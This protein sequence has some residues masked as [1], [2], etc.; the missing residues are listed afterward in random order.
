MSRIAALACLLFLAANI[1]LADQP[2]PYAGQQLREIKALAPQDV[3]QY[4]EGKGMGLA[5]AAELNHFPGPMHVLQFEGKLQ[6]T[7][8]QKTQTEKIFAAMQLE[9]S[10]LGAPLVDKE[11]ELDRLFASGNI[12]A[13]RLGS[14]VMEIGRL[15]AAVRTAHLRAHLEQKAILTPVQIAAYDELRGYAQDNASPHPRNADGH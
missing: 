5:K 3:Q 13:E 9:S 11:R 7:P 4:L 6:I 1:A 2:S 8:E 14:L 12:E 15:Q 10:S